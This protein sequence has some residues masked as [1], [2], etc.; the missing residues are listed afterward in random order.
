MN[1]K[2]TVVLAF[3]AGLLGSAVFR[4]A[5]PSSVFAQDQTPVAKEIRA[6]NIV[7]VDQGNN[8][9]GTFTSEAGPGSV[10]IGPRVEVTSPLRI[11]LRDRNGRTIWTP[12]ENTK[13]LPLSLK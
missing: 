4:Y 3:A 6:Q 8:V 9:I 1:S 5:G 12:G 2:L 11:V 10:R 13:L 7:L